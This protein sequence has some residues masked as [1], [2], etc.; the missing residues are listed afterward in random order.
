MSVAAQ[1]AAAVPDARYYDPNTFFSYA[2]PS[3]NAVTNAALDGQYASGAAYVWDA[4]EP[5]VQS[6]PAYSSSASANAYHSAAAPA[7][8][9]PSGHSSVTASFAYSAPTDFVSSH[10]A[11]PSNVSR[12]APSSSLSPSS[13]AVTARGASSSHRGHSY[14]SGARSY[15]S[16]AAAATTNASNSSSSTPRLQNASWDNAAL[17]TIDPSDPVSNAPPQQHAYSRSSTTSS[18]PATPV[19]PPIKE[20]D[21]E[22]EFIIEVSVPADPVPSSMPEVPLR[23]THAPPKMRSMMCSFRLESFAMHDGIRS[24][25]TQPGPGGIVVGPLKEQPIEFE[26]QADLVE[27]L[28]P[29]EEDAYRYGMAQGKARAQVG[30]SPSV[31]SPPSPRR[32][33]G[34]N[35]LRSPRTGR[36]RAD[37]Y[38]AVGTASPAL[39]LDYPQQ[40]DSGDGWDASSAYGSAADNG[41]GSGTTS[42]SPTFAPIM[43]PAQSLGWSLRYQS[44][45]VDNTM[46]SS[47]GYHRQQTVTQPSRAFFFICVECF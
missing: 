25:A 46:E 11:Y 34:G 42:A 13:A 4:H 22:G 7:S 40:V 36:T 28:V 31:H 37:S 24:A 19:S 6:P 17:Y 1:Y 29:Q 2:P 32:T 44:G 47:G 35:E 30:Y 26:W 43:T 10:R 14:S 20:E 23:A 9:A 16:L 38:T 33:G 27:P 45:D 5:A 15:S 39:S 21:P 18:V 3:L 8:S 12:V 41:S